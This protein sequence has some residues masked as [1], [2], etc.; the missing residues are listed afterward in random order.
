MEAMMRKYTMTIHLILIALM[1]A[2]PQAQ[3]GKLAKAKSDIETLIAAS[4]AETVGVAVADLQTHQTLLINERASLHAAS[5]MKL[6][7][8][9]EIFRLVDAKKLGLREPIEVKNKFFSIADGSEYRLS[10]SDDSD[11]EK[12]RNEFHSKQSAKS[13]KLDLFQ[14]EEW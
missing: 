10:K 9:M 5:T 3:S 12:N 8:M 6:P 1:T 2:N 13:R 7:V 14:L 11:D 4:K